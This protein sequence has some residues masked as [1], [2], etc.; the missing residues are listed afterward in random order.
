MGIDPTGGRFT[1]TGVRIGIIDSGCDTTHPLLRH[2]RHGKD[3][4]A[5]AT[6]TSWAQDSA[7]QGTHCAGIINASGSEQ[8]IIGCAPEAELHIFKVVP[9]GRISNLLAALDECIERELDVIHISVVTEGFSELVSQ[10]LKEARQKG[11]ICVAAAGTAAGSMVFPVNVS[12]GAIAVAAVGRLKQFPPDSSH[13][14]NV[15]PQLIGS[16]GLFAARFSGSGPQIA[17]CA[18]GVAIVSTVPGAGYLAADGTPAAA[19]HVTGFVALVL[20]HH[21]LFQ[22]E[23]LFTLRTEQRVQALVDLMQAS[24]LAHFLDPQYSG[25]GVPDLARVPG[26]QSFGTGLPSVDGVERVVPNPYLFGSRPGWPWL[27][28]Q[29]APRFY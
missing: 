11:I 7:S 16:D 21:P 3:F 8:G 1:G 23:G 12:G 13:V 4:T 27:P 25:W 5:G 15:I 28:N 6:D 2:I 17:V 20:A 29:Q 19:A 9:D 26:G 22:Q 14:L 18:P 10:K 24:A